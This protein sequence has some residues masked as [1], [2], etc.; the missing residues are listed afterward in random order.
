MGS[1]V[2]LEPSIPHSSLAHGVWERLVAANRW[3]GFVSLARIS[4][5]VVATRLQPCRSRILKIHVS[6]G[7]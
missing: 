4:S 5:E 6:R 3:G 2:L 7:E 1:R